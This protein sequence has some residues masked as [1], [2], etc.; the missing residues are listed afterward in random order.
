M[1]RGKKRSIPMFPPELLGDVHD[2]PDCQKDTA[3][4]I[5]AT[6]AIAKRRFD[7]SQPL[8]RDWQRGQSE[9]AFETM[10]NSDVLQEIISA[11]RIGCTSHLHLSQIAMDYLTQRDLENTWIGLGK[12]GQEVHI[13]KAHRQQNEEDNSPMGSFSIAKT[14]C[15][16]L[17]SDQLM[18]GDGKGFI[19]LLQIF[20]LENNQT[21]PTQPFILENTRYD[22]IIGWMGDDDPGKNRKICLGLRRLLRTYHICTCSPS[23]SCSTLN[24]IQRVSAYT[25]SCPS[26][27]EKSNV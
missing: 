14:D 12:A 26:T 9:S 23:C 5:N 13:F 10:M 8:P 20:L 7:P 27:A 18:R 3:A 1:A 15:P 4:W 22:E 6:D 2:L 17:S 21:P 19:E 25:F 24:S 16:E 11:R